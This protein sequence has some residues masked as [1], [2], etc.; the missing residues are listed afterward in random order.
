MALH[1]FLRHQIDKQERSMTPA[2]AVSWSRQA[3]SEVGAIDEWRQLLAE[4]TDHM[5]STLAT[6]KLAAKHECTIQPW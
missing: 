3:H 1:K 2:I 5:P 4:P 6:A